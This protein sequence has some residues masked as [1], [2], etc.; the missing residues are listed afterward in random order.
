MPQTITK[1][2][3]YTPYEWGIRD[4][5]GEIIAYIKYRVN[6]QDYS[7]Y[8]VDADVY[9]EFEKEGFE[10]MENFESYADAR[11]W[12]NNKVYAEGE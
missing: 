9:E 3:T 1:I 5:N 10:R 12:L 4:K 6:N 7:F 11:E 2:L 8:G